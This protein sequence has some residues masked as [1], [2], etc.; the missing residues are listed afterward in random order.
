[1]AAR[2]P[3]KILAGIVKG[4][5][6]EAKLGRKLAANKEQNWLLALTLHSLAKLD[7]NA[8]LTDLEQSIVRAFREHG[9]S[10]D[11]LKQQGKLYRELPDEA[12]REIFPG[13]F[14]GLTAQANYT[15]Q[16]L[17]QDAPQIVTSI[18][19]MPNTTNVDIEAIHAGTASPADFPMPSRDVLRQHGGAMFVALTPDTTGTMTTG[20]A[21]T[22][23]ITG[24]NITGT[25]T[26]TITTGTNP[27]YTIKATSF[28][29]NDE[30]GTDWFGSDEPFW[31]C[32]T[33]AGKSAV[34]TR[35]QIFGD[36]DSGETRNFAANEGCI[37]GQDC[38]AQEF[39]GEVIGSLIQLWEH[40]QGDPEKIKDAVEVSFAVAAA[41][42]EGSGVAAW[43]G[44]VVAGVGAVVKW[45]LG[46][47]DDDHIADQTFVFTRQALEDQLKKVGSSMNITSRFTDGDGDYTLT[48]AVNRVA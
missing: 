20:T 1:M 48:I 2:E 3:A 23:T 30:T 19:A 18:L 40:D 24:T 31:I 25:T 47:M 17:Q 32:G 33:L 21:T 34:T 42:L 37:W 11:E 15:V 35:S 14:A 29:C 16:D 22:G 8:P 38:A 45:L 41:V 28:R 9:F 27:R 36:V 43:I 12:R 6:R 13:K 5:G 26:G 44:A 7:S 4:Q 46:F 39:P 10:D